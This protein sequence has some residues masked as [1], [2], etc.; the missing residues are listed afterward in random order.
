[1]AVCG[2]VGSQNFGL[3]ANPIVHDAYCDQQPGVGFTH[4]WTHR[5]RGRANST[6]CEV[7]F[8]EMSQTCPEGDEHVRELRLT[9]M[10]DVEV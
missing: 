10:I 7:D 3:S 5:K 4:V 6:D 8:N 9:A 1:M 2:E